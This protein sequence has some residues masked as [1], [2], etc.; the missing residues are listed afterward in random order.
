MPS[1]LEI[2]GCEIAKIREITE[3]AFDGRLVP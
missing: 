1:W 3:S 2:L